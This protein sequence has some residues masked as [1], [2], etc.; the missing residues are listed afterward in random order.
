MGI[1]SFGKEYGTEILTAIAQDD[2]ASLRTILDKYLK[3]KEKFREVCESNMRHKPSKTVACPMILASRLKN[4]TILRYMVENGVNPNFVY[5][6]TLSG[7]R[8]EVITPLHI[9]VDL[10][11]YGVVDLLLKFNASCGIMDH[12]GETPLLVA[13]Q[14]A[15]CTMVRML[16]AKGADPDFADRLGNTCLHIAT[17]LGHLQLVRTLIRFNA[18]VNLKGHDGAI[19]VQ[20]AAKEGHVHLVELFGSME[21]ATINATIPCFEDGREKAPL[22]L[23]A[24]GGHF[25]TVKAILAVPGSDVNVLDNNRNTA[26]HY[27]VMAPYNSRR[28]RE[29]RAIP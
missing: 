20:I 6:R 11:H 13:V 7:T 25:E 8:K 18:N 14:K 5:Y 17:K 28:V 24:S 15:D 2:V 1:K 22:H 3:S 10:A 16:L 26:L 27:V 23:A 29:R 19:P 12:N 4:P 9:A 21:N